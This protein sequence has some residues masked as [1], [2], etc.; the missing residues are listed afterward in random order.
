[1]LNENVGILEREGDDAS[2]ATSTLAQLPLKAAETYR[3]PDAFKFKRNRQWIL[4]SH[5]EFLRCV[6]ELFFALRTLGV[7][8]GDRVAIMSENRVEWAIV[9]FAALSAGAITVPI[10]P[11][12]SAAQVT[13]LLADSRPVVVFVSSAQLLQKL[14]IGNPQFS[15]R[16]V[17]ALD[18]GIA[19]QREGSSSGR[20]CDDH[21]YVRY[22]RD[23]KRRNADASQS[24]LEYCGDPRCVAS[25]FR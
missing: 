17:V 12:L 1:M 20:R 10:Y 3:K 15:A 5:D 4:L 7:Q 2:L 14:Q 13:A 18:P 11:T 19:A 24:H 9:D 22:N 8:R 25:G 16:Y 6:E 21:L 23:S